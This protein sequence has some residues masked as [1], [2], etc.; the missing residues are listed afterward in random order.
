MIRI[1]FEQVFIY[2]LDRFLPGP[3][4]RHRKKQLKELLQDERFP[5]GR[6][7]EELRQRTGTTASVC[8]ELLSE[9]KAEGFKQDDGR[10]GWRFRES[11]DD[12]NLDS[13]VPAQSADSAMTP[14]ELADILTQMHRDAPKGHATTMVHLFGIRYF[15]EIHDCQGSVKEIVRLSKIPNSYNREVR[16][17]IRLARYVSARSD[18]D[19]ANRRCSPGG[20]TS[21]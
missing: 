10:E 16:E 21:K 20:G 8:R 17:G 13:P 3:A 19:F 14:R 9:I 2:L 12:D 7:L 4:K 1:G 6:P 5:D 11:R 18:C 15:E